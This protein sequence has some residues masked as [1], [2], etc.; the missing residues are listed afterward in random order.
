MKPIFKIE[1]VL[2]TVVYCPKCDKNSMRVRLTP[3]DRDEENRGWRWF[4][5]E[6]DYSH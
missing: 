5:P 1:P 2:E 3:A 4:C 6:C